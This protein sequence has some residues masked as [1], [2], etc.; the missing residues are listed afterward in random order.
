MA[1]YT[2]KQVRD[3]LPQHIIDKQGP[4]YEGDAGYDGDQWTAAADYITELKESL[5]AKDRDLA[6]ANHALMLAN[7]NAD[8]FKRVAEQR[9]G[10][11]EELTRKLALAEDQSFQWRQKYEN[12]DNYIA[13]CLV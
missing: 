10:E 11:I 13:G 3:L 8:A 6:D 5:A 9:Q 12:L 1:Y 2:Y 4:D 7:S